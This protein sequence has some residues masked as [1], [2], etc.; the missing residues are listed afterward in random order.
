MAAL[1][2]PYLRAADV[3]AAERLIQFVRS[4]PLG[5]IIGST[6]AMMDPPS[7]DPPPDGEYPGFAA[8]RAVGLVEHHHPPPGDHHSKGLTRDFDPSVVQA[9]W[10]ADGRIV[11]GAPVYS[12]FI[13]R[14]QHLDLE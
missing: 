7:L 8:T 11:P 14:K 4:Q 2:Q 9:E 13:R 1:L 12:P 6:P 10:G 3:A 5:A